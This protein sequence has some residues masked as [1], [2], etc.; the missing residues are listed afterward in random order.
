[1]L[2]VFKSFFN[3]YPW[4]FGYVVSPV[5]Y[6]TASYK[7]LIFAS[8]GR[9]CVP[10]LRGSLTSVPSLCDYYSNCLTF[11]WCFHFARR[12]F[13]VVFVNRY[14]GVEVPEA[15][16]SVT[17]F[18]YY[19]L[20][21]LI[22]GVCASKEFLDVNGIPSL[23]WVRLGLGLFLVGQ[24]GNSYCHYILR[25][26][27]P[28]NATHYVIPTAFPFNHIIAPHYTFELLSWFGFALASGFTPPSLIIFILSVGILV[29]WATKRRDKYVKMYK[30]GIATSND[31]G[32][33]G[34]RWV[35]IPLVL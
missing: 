11:C 2:T 22:N 15:R 21:G 17:E 7:P 14:R 4:L 28:P 6:L 32:D 26:L 23:V 1:M 31:I 19:L 13:E 16:D 5:A 25:N 29:P 35:I 27:R 9:Y 18:M 12:A 3:R 8:L 30:D 24:F 34:K 10:L 20:W 33:P